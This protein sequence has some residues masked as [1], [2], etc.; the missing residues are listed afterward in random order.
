MILITLIIVKLTGFEFHI[1]YTPN[2]QLH[3][4]S[5]P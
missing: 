5:K 1:L 4:Q 2:R 3:A